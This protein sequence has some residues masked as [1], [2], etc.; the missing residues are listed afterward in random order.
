GQSLRTFPSRI[1]AQ[2]VAYSPDGENV[3]SAS[4]DNRLRV[5][6]VSSGKLLRTLQGHIGSV[7]TVAYSPDG[8]TLVSGSDDKTLRIW[9]ATSGQLLRTLEG[10]TDAVYA[11]VYSP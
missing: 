1:D 10:H 7:Q 2:A 6:E 8:K 3:I 9:D 11:V 4:S 5:W